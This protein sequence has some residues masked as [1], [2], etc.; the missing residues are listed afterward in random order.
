LP[1]FSLADSWCQCKMPLGEGSHFWLLSTSKCKM[2]VLFACT[3][4]RENSNAQYVN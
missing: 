4:G 2:A 1:P 3:V